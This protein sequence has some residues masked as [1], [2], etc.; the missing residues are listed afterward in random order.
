MEL[1]L[2]KPMLAV[3]AKP[4]DSADYL[5]EVKWDGYRGLAYLDGQTV[6]RS[7][8]LAELTPTF[9]ELGGLHMQ[10]A[11]LPAILDGEIVVTA[12]GV[13]SFSALQSR[14]RLVDEGRIKKA[15]AEL[16]AIFIAFDVLYADGRPVINQPLISRKKLLA[17]IITPG[18]S[19][20]ISEYITENGTAFY[21]ACIEKD[22]EGIVAKRLDSSYLPGKRSAYWK[23]IRHVKSAELAICG[24]EPGRG[25]N[26]LGSLILGG[27]QDGELIYRGKVGTGF[28]RQEQQRLMNLLALLTAD[29]PPFFVPTKNDL[30]SPKWVKPEL[31]CEVH[32]SEL[33][34][35]GRLRHP[36]YKGL[37]FDKTVE[38]ITL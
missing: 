31:V 13:P 35:D 25:A 37:R 5:Y 3:P 1:P 33:T 32:F 23:K 28:S 34:A 15:A 6:I 10:A 7:R 19:F 29:Q 20:V 26:L 24:Y 22:L 14:G 16:P 38:E 8:N 36:S 18:G 27:R 2:L 30:R 9:P 17:D 11:C 21:Q 4:F 12:G